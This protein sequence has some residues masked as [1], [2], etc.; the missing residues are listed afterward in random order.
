MGTLK[1]VAKQTFLLQELRNTFYFGGSDSTI[2]N[3]QA[4]ADGVRGAYAAGSG[5]FSDQWTLYAVDIYNMDTP[6][7]PGVEFSFTSGTYSGA[8]TAEPMPTQVAA[9][10]NFQSQTTAPNRARKYIGGLASD[11]VADGLLI[12]ACITGLE[13]FADYLLDFASNISLTVNFGSVS[14][15]PNVVGAN[16]YLYN[17][18]A[19]RRINP[20]PGVQR[21]RRI[22]LGS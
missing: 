13:D 18:M 22:G 12:T 2:A 16:P 6:G 21:S 1:V 20:V 7:V 9:I 5:I 3:G 4:I 17:D 8:L 19:T 15:D 10:M 14:T 11:R